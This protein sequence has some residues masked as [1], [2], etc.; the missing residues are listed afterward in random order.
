[1]AVI[2]ATIEVLYSF[3]TITLVMP[4]FSELITTNESELFFNLIEPPIPMNGFK[5]NSLY[6]SGNSD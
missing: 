3:D 2:G 4:R 5:A 6:R 1:M